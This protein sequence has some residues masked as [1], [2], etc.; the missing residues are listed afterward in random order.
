[1]VNL[2]DTQIFPQ[3]KVVTSMRKRFRFRFPEISA[4]FSGKTEIFTETKV[5]NVQEKQRYS[6]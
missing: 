5:L 2:Q 4:T 6:L 1:M 3:I